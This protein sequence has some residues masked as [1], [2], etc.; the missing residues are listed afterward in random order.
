MQVDASQD[1]VE[2]L[3]EGWQGKTAEVM[4]LRSRWKL[5]LGRMQVIIAGSLPSA[6]LQEQDCQY[7]I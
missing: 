6:R 1:A 2:S 5:A 3:R 4:E 7:N